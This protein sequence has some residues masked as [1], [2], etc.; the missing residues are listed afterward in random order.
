MLTA[1][2]PCLSERVAILFNDTE[3]FHS[4]RPLNEVVQYDG[5]TRTDTI[6]LLS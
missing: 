5:D 1:V 6:K 3:I 2:R 4:I